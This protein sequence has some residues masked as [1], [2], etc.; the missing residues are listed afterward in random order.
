MRLLLALALLSLTAASRTSAERRLH[1]PEGRSLLQAGPLI[2]AMANPPSKQ[3]H[4]E[5]FPVGDSRRPVTKGNM[6][7]NA[8]PNYLRKE[9]TRREAERKKKNESQSSGKRLEN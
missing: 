5:H 4:P 7:L 2:R 9:A 6:Y 1:A 8:N 3:F